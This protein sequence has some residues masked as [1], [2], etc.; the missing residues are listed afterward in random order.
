MREAR[1]P[2]MTQASRIPGRP[3]PE[4]SMGAMSALVRSKHHEYRILLGPWTPLSRASASTLA[5]PNPSRSLQCCTARSL[6]AKA[7]Y[8]SDSLTATR[9]RAGSVGGNIG[10]HPQAPAM[11]PGLLPLRSAAS[12]RLA[13]RWVPRPANG[14]LAV[15]Q[16]PWCSACRCKPVSPA[17]RGPRT[18]PPVKLATAKGRR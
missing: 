9:P 11:D 16:A 14:R 10:T 5:S 3:P 13:R 2:F 6:A 1:P 12:R 17:G 7:N 8:R 4:T 18:G 15:L